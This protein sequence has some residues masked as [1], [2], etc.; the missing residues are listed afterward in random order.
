MSKTKTTMTSDINALTTDLAHLDTL[1]AKGELT[2]E[3]DVD[4]AELFK[5]LESAEGV[6]GDVE[7]RIDEILAKL[8]E[9]LE[10]IGVPEKL[11]DAVD[12]AQPKVGSDTQ[13][14]GD[15]N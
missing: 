3:E 4:V 6:A 8:D 11:E 13:T 1:L 15:S 10:D 7:G 14:K 2:E 9:I 5:R 12:V